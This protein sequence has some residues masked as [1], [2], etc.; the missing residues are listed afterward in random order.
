MEWRPAA[1][2]AVTRP[3]TGPTPARPGKHRPHTAPHS[4]TPLTGKGRGKARSPGRRRPGAV[5]PTHRAGTLAGPAGPCAQPSEGGGGLE[6]RGGRP[7]RHPLGRLP[8]GSRR[9]GKVALW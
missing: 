2:P 3:P 9:T 6:V 5:A 1:R 7:G 8:P 4:T